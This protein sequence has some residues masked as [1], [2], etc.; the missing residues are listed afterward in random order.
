MRPQIDQTVS[1]WITGSR[2]EKGSDPASKGVFVA[3]L[4][5]PIFETYVKVLHWIDACY[6][7]I[8]N[9]LSQPEKTILKIPSCEPLRSFVERRR[10]ASLGNR[11]KW[12]ELTELL[13]VPFVP[14][15]CFEWFR[16]R[17]A[18]PWCLNRFIGGSR[19][20]RKKECAALVS[21]LTQIYGEN[22]CFYRFSDIPFLHP[23]LENEPRLFTGLLR[24]ICDFQQS[25]NM[26]F[27]Y[28]WPADR[29]WCVCS[30]Y[31]LSVTIVAGDK[32]LISK[33]LANEVLE[34]IRITT[35]SRVDSRAPIP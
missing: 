25:R 34:C 11:I 33:L 29:R 30:D 32:Q 8:D 15:I 9:P 19:D 3:N 23:T 7:D 24:E 20:G 2:T 6:D 5:P 1:D 14:E 13:N 12:K 16:R 22:E 10:T 28:W 31:D 21:T 4:I 26:E 17:L 27:E 35:Q 18:D